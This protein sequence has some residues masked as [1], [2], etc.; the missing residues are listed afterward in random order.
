[1]AARTARHHSRIGA[2]DDRVA[3]MSYGLPV[4]ATRGEAPA[5]E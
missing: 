4:R 3:P 2:R 5:C 1:M